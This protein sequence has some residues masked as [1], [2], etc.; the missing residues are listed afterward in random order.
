MDV[1][2]TVSQVSR[3]AVVGADGAGESTVIKGLVGEQLPISGFIWK[4]A[5]LR[6]G[7]VVSLSVFHRNHGIG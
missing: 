5:S 3:V 7:Q 6:L 4:A 2:L 1:N